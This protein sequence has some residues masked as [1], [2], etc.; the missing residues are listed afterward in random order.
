MHHR[1]E[2]EKKKRG[3]DL[4]TLYT[5]TYLYI[6]VYVIHVRTRYKKQ[7]RAEYTRNESLDTRAHIHTYT[8]AR[9]REQ[10]MHVRSYVRE[11]RARA[12]GKENHRGVHKRRVRSEGKGIKSS[13]R[14]IITI[15]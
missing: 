8:R 3:R 7:I 9:I 11:Y 1:I 12:P 13:T 2:R 10:W 4:Y 6:N 14:L 15:L 5:Y